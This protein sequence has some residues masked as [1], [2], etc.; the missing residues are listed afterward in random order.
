MTSNK[1]TIVI[2]EK[3]LVEE[4]PKVTKNTQI[5][6]EKF[7]Q[8]KGYYHSVYVIIYINNQVGVDMK[9]QQAD[10]EDDPDEQEMEDMKLDDDTERCWRMVFEDNDGG[11][12]DK[13]SLLNTKR[14]DVYI[15]KH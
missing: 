2:L 10:V 5:P 6:E 14:W 11:V 7:T 12:Y 9:Q 15:G 1:L 4:E 8:E 3:S 13:K